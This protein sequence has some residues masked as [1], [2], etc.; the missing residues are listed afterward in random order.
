MTTE[1]YHGPAG[2]VFTDDE[3]LIIWAYLTRLPMPE[4]SDI[5]RRIRVYLETKGI[6]VEL[7]T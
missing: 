5:R 2:V 7:R 4:N 1:T 6:K 3:L